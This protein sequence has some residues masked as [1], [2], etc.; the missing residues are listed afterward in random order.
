VDPLA[1]REGQES[2]TPY[3]YGFDNPARYNDPDGRCPTC[4]DDMAE[5]IAATAVSTV[6]GLAVSTFNTGIIAM[7][8]MSALTGLVTGRGLGAVRASVD[9]NGDIQVG[10]RAAPTSVG[11]AAGY[12]ASDA[13][14]V[15]NTG[16][17]VGTGGT[18]GAAK[19]GVVIMAKTGAKTGVVN[20]LVQKAKGGVYALLNPSNNTVI[21]TGRTTNLE[22][23]KVQHK[24]G[25]ET[26]NADFATLHETDDYATQR[27]LEHLEHQ[28]HASTAD[29][30]NGGL[31]KIK[32]MSDKKAA[33][34]KGKGYIQKAMEFLGLE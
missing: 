33:S 3:H 26:K 13:L 27:G 32:A 8:P 34:D 6:K 21:R 18:G 25:K 28:K 12:L 14:D 20:A 17:T 5:T 31:N 24:G 10:Q 16:L 7:N 11:Q 29:A 23:R 1:D 2:W 4:G 19:T 22:K 9:D 15:A 30:K